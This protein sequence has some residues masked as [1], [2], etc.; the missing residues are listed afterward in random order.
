MNHQENKEKNAVLIRFKESKNAEKYFKKYQG[1]IDNT[2]LISLCNFDDPHSLKAELEKARELL[3]LA[4]L[5]MDSW[6]NLSECD[7]DSIFEW[8]RM[9]DEFLSKGKE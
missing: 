5:E 1:Q 6:R 4:R 7:A 9:H 2:D 8:Y 3:R